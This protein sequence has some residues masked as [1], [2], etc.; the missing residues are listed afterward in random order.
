MPHSSLALSHLSVSNSHLVSRRNSSPVSLSSPF[1]CR[2]SASRSEA[3]R[4]F[5][6]YP[7]IDPRVAEEILSSSGVLAAIGVVPRVAEALAG[8]GSVDVG[9]VWILFLISAMPCGIHALSRVFPMDLGDG[10]V[11]ELLQTLG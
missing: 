7:F 4:G 8:R 9:F 3:F 11:A 6:G 1:S 2:R 10:R 5:L